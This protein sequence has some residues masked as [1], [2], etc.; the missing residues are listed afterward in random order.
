MTKHYLG[1]SL[2]FTLKVKKN[3]LIKKFTELIII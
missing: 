2:E 3:I 1:Q